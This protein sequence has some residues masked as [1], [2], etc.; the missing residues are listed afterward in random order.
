MN[1]TETGRLQA[2]LDDFVEAHTLA[3]LIGVNPEDEWFKPRLWTYA[4]R[5][6]N[7]GWITDSEGRWS[8]HLVESFLQFHRILP[9]STACYRLG[10]D[11]NSLQRTLQGLY[12]GAY[13]PDTAADYPDHIIR[14]EL[15]KEIHRYLPST[16]SA[17]FNN[18]SDYCR[19]VHSA[20][21]SDL[22]IEVTPLYCE[23]SRDLEESP[24]NLSYS[25]C[26][27]SHQPVGIRYKVMLNLGKP[28]RLPPDLISL[29]FFQANREHL[30]QYLMG[31]EP[32]TAQE[33]AS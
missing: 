10:M 23:T 15:V 27:L 19:R 4:T 8:R 16:Q 22:D 20:I 3:A 29:R 32:T 33:R 9:I 24:P 5:I 28:L 30:Q 31:S 11:Q 2:L 7:R 18:H 25:R 26:C 6:R 1:E 17:L 21:R 14:E 12:D 13:I